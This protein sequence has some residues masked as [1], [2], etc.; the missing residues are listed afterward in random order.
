MEKCQR[1]IL[2]GKYFGE[3]RN[4]SL[5]CFG[6]EEK[7]KGLIIL[8]EDKEDCDLFEPEEQTSA[9]GIGMVQWISI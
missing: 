6:K 5:I 4:G 1:C 2:S 3:F 8:V 7:L 9:I